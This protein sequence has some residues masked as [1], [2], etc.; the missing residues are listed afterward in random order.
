MEYHILRTQ[1]GA[2]CILSWKARDSLHSFFFFI[3]IWSSIASVSFASLYGLLFYLFEH[4]L[5]SFVLPLLSFLDTRMVS[6]SAVQPQSIPLLA[7]IPC[8]LDNWLT[9]SYMQP[10]WFCD[11][12]TPYHVLL[13]AGSAYLPGFL[14]ICSSFKGRKPHIFKN[15]W[16]F[17]RLHRFFLHLFFFIIIITHYNLLFLM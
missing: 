10:A 7:F 8:H 17:A 15:F 2:T 9:C 13:I 11:I 16:L 3:I 6:S 12:V 4:A 1:Y 5:G 14:V